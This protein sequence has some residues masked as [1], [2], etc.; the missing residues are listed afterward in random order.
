[1]LENP[2]GTLCLGK[3]SQR[4][5]TFCNIISSSRLLIQPRGVE[6]A[7]DFFV[8]LSRC[9]INKDFNFLIFLTFK[10]VKSPAFGRENVRFP[11][12]PDFAE[13]PD[14]T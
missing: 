6:E 1:M 13:L 5:S 8:I 9:P 12:C 7:H 2:H 14:W 11:D 10:S 3:S 4:R